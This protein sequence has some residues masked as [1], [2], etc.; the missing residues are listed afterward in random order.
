MPK[1]CEICL[2]GAKMVLF[3]TGVCDKSCFYCPLSEKRRGLDI[4]Y[5]DELLVE[6]DLDLILEGRSIDAEGTGITGGDPILK[7]NRTLR[8]MR[9][10]KDFFG[11]R[12]HIHLYTNGRYINRDALL[13]LKEAG[14]D[15]LRFHPDARDWGKIASAKELGIYTGVE[16]PAIPGAEGAL[17]DLINYLASIK[18]DFLNLNELE[19][20]PPNSYQLKQRGFALKEGS[21][22]AA[23]NSEESALKL[24]EW[25]KSEGIELPIHFCSSSTK[26]AVQTS[27]RIRRRGKNVVRPYEEITGEGLLSKYR[28]EPLIGSAWDLRAKIIA[29]LVV[30]PF[31]VGISSDGNAVETSKVLVRSVSLLSRDSR[32]AYVEEYPTATREKFAEYPYP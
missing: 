10:L 28:V 11:D 23:K 21:M 6:E 17:K 13:K 5:A 14:L 29:D 31:L 20:C 8:Y 9:V 26:D 2:S 18:A 1:G 24:V 15:E 16:V 19:F 12:H 3:V 4:V 32:I 25:A 30:P 22:A 7:L 27:K